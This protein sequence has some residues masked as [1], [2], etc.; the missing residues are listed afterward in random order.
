MMAHITSISDH[1]LLIKHQNLTLYVT[2]N[3]FIPNKK[4]E[5]VLSKK[6]LS[7]GFDIRNHGQ[8][9]QEIV[10]L[11]PLY[12][13]NITFAAFRIPKGLPSALYFVHLRQSG[14]DS[15]ERLPLMLLTNKITDTEVIAIEPN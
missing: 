12:V 1:V 3:Y 15:N 10:V 8:R 7:D 5:L 4:I 2:A 11:S 13:K 9:M 14:Q 6:K